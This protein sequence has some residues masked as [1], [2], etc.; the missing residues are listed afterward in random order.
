[1]TDQP[2]PDFVV[3]GAMKCGTSALHAH[4]DLHPQIAMAPG[5]ELNFFF[6]SSQ[7]PDV[8]PSQWWR[9]GQWHRGLQWYAEQ[10][11][12]GAQLRGESSP[13]YT[14][15][16]R[17]EVAERMR[18]VLPGVRLIYLVRDPVARAASQWDHHVRD[19]SEPLPL[20]EALLDPERQYL[21]RSRYVERLRPFLDTFDPAQ[22]LI[23]VNER[24]QRDPRNQLRRIFEHV[25]ADPDFW[26]DAMTS[27]VHDGRTHE[28][29]GHVRRRFWDLVGDDVDQ[30]RSLLEDD[31]PEWTDP[32]VPPRRRRR[33][34]SEALP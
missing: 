2:L 15:P 19:G 17:T 21:A 29:P 3:I 10:F 6:G 23:V 14:A 28:I 18:R 20:D 33:R 32:T 12:A 22:L 11:P 24:L 1:M 26:T 7:A 8:E 34:A 4:L 16:G 13:G 27:R 5:K 30:L 31:L 25:G 9:H